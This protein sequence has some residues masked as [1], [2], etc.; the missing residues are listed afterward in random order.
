M[1]RDRPSPVV[2]GL[3]GDRLARSR[4]GRRAGDYEMDFRFSAS[5][6]HWY[7]ATLR[8]ARE[9]LREPGSRG[10]G[11]D[12][13]SHLSS[14]IPHPSQG[15]WRE[16]FRRCARFGIVGLPIPEEHGG[17]GQDLPTTV[18]AMEA[19]GYGYNDSGLIFAINAAL[20]TVTMPIIRFG[21]EEQKRRYLPGLCDGRLLGANGASEPEAGSD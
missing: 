16:G 9:E 10:E 18:A 7:D 3:S 19:L 14:L 12:S 17:R 15:F 1:N 21:T 13:D 8:F 20:W 11:G 6:Q 5:Q 4:A 2:W